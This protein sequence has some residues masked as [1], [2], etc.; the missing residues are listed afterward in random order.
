MTSRLESTTMSMD[1]DEQLTLVAPLFWDGWIGLCICINRLFD[2]DYF[3]WSVVW[4]DLLLHTFSKKPI[5]S[6]VN[7]A[8]TTRCLGS[9]LLPSTYFRALMF[10][11]PRMVLCLAISRLPDFSSRVVRVRSKPSGLKVQTVR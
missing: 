5:N 1:T 8:D 6:R 7:N 3:N 9:V 4:N 11:G 2:F 10:E